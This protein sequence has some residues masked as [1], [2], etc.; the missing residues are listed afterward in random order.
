[1]IRIEE[2]VKKTEII[3]RIAKMGK[4]SPSV[5]ERIA[6]AL[7]EKARKIGKTDSEEV[8]GMSALAEILKS[9]DASFESRLLTELDYEDP[10]LSYDLRARLYTLD[11]VTRMN[12]IALEEKLRSMSE[13][14]VVFLLK[15][16]NKAFIDK[17]LSN[18]SAPRRALI[19]E[20]AD[21]LGPVSRFEADK[22]AS[23]FLTWF[24]RGRETGEILLYDDDDIIL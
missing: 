3:K 12:D 24:R 17:I 4:V 14:E 13:K 19:R 1:V 5:L 21:I 15:G 11:D 22:V 8:D 10:T 7:K 18:M 16:R 20:E 23:D 9:S 6:A 2:P